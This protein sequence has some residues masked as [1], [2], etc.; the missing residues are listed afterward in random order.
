VFSAAQHPLDSQPE[1][2]TLY[3]RNPLAPEQEETEPAGIAVMKQSAKEFASKMKQLTKNYDLSDEQ[4]RL[5]REM[6]PLRHIDPSDML[7]I[8]GERYNLPLAF[9]TKATVEEGIQEG[10][11]LLGFPD[12]HYDGTYTLLELPR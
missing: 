2:Q 11:L 4:A 3:L 12:D 7:R 5:Q 8:A 10:H 9:V 1:T 6:I